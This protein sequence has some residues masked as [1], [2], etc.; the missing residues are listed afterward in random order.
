MA[1]VSL[2]PL[3]SLGAGLSKQ[4]RASLATCPVC[5][6]GDE[7]HER[8]TEARRQRGWGVLR[9]HAYLTETCGVPDIENRHTYNHVHRHLDAEGRCLAKSLPSTPTKRKK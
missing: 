9:I 4:L 5:A 1:T 7:Y 3:D 2:P 6:L 8:I